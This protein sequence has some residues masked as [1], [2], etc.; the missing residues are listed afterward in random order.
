MLVKWTQNTELDLGGYDI[1]FGI[2]NDG[3]ADDPAHFVYTRTM[4]PKEIVTGTSNLVDGKLWGLDDNVE[5]YY[6]IRAHD[7]NN[8]YSEWAA[9]QTGKPW[10]LAPKTWTPTPNSDSNTLGTTV[11]I[12]F[13]VPLVA[14]SVQSGITVLDANGQPVAGTISLLTNLDG[15]K[16]IGA[17][18]K[19]TSALAALSS[20]S[21]KLKGGANGVTAEDG[22]Q[23]PAD[24]A[25]TFKTGKQEGKVVFLPL[26]RK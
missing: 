10:P 11:D 3:N 25:W 6:S 7:N 24:Y 15:D 22:R 21:A 12:A 16:V 1:G 2:V 20:F 5:M 26:I 8:N 17:S 4:G 14:T 19:P 18:F 9:M 23:M 13:G